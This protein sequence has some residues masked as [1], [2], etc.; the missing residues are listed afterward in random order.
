MNI[1]KRLTTGAVA[2]G[3]AGA[4]VV[5]GAGAAQAGTSCSYY[6]TTHNAVVSMCVTTYAD[7][8][9]GYLHWSID[10]TAASTDER[11]YFTVQDGGGCSSS[12]NYNDWQQRDGY[13]YTFCGTPVR[14]S[15]YSTESGANSS[16]GTHYTSWVS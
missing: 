16:G 7:H 9:G 2:L 1:V 4:G 10:T 6:R 15:S 5:A 13:L 3:L 14:A 11:M 12:G 8:S